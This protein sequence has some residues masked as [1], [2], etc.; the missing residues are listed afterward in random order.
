MDYGFVDNC[1]NKTKGN[2]KM[3]NLVFISKKYYR[4]YGVM[5][6]KCN[7]TF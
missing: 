4:G 6:V 7:L 3:K 5:P 1:E 2:E